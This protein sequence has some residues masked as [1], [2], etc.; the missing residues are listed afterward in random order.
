MSNQPTV[1]KA[2][3]ALLQT[4]YSKF[5]N[6]PTTSKKLT[7]EERGIRKFF[8]RLTQGVKK[9]PQLLGTIALEYR[10]PVL[11]DLAIQRSGLAIADTPPEYQTVERFFKAAKKNADAIR[12]AP[13]DIRP[14]L[15]TKLAVDKMIGKSNFGRIRNWFQNIHDYFTPQPDPIEQRMVRCLNILNGIGCEGYS[16]QQ[17]ENELKENFSRLPDNLKMTDFCKKVIQYNPS[18]ATFIPDSESTSE[19]MQT[20]IKHCPSALDNIP[21][22]KRS[23]E[24][25][26]LAYLRDKQTLGFTP[27]ALKVEVVENAKKFEKEKD[28]VQNQQDLEKLISHWGG[29]VSDDFIQQQISRFASAVQ[30]SETITTAT[31]AKDKIQN[32]IAAHLQTNMPQSHSIPDF[33]LNI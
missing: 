13:E 33:S 6:L 15:E 1:R 9:E 32:N 28:A 3:E 2:L 19:I 16:R 29:A 7:R 5:G 30:Q 12:Y 26:L 22:T 14:L 10:V 23:S 31:T 27:P 17:L 25:C 8:T 21:L 20:L 11:C 24:L 4:Y 18:C